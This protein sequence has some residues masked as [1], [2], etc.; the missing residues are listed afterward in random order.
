MVNRTVI[1]GRVALSEEVALHG[2]VSG[3]EPLPINLIE[4]I[5]LENER[6]NGTGSRASLHGDGDL[7]EEDVFSTLDGRCIG[8]L[9]DRKLSTIRSRVCQACAILQHPIIALSLGEVGRNCRSQRSVAR[10]G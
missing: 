3:S 10:A 6:A 7:S 9:R 8:P 2:R 5:G 4:I 1:G